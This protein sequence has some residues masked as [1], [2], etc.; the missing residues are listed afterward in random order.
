MEKI[1]K[2]L[3]EENIDSI[4]RFA[5]FKMQSNEEEVYDIIQ[6]SFYKMAIELEK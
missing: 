4:Y 2:K 3:Y 5:Y 1:I 6:E